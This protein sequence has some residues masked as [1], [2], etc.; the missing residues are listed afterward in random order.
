MMP[1]GVVAAVDWGGTWIRVALATREGD[2]LRTIRRRRPAEVQAQCDLVCDLVAELGG[3]A[4]EPATALGVGIAGITRRGYVES[5][6]NIGIRHPFPLADRL[7]DKS[8]LPTVVV[9]DTQAAAIAEAAVL[10][11]GT[12]VL[13]TAG[14]GI[15]G[16]IVADGRLV[17][18]AGAAGDYGHMVVE[19]DGPACICGGRGCLE[20]VISGRTLN[21]VATRLADSGASQ[22]LV[23]RA[24][25]QG[26]VHAGDL[27]LA[28]QAGDAA[29]SRALAEAAAALV[30]GLRSITAAIDPDVIVLGGGLLAPGL[31]LTAL[32]QERWRTQRPPWTKAELRL[33]SF[34]SEAGLRGAAL[35]ASRSNAANRT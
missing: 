6:S 27:E 19:I 25:E 9:N 26:T 23:T 1:G 16:A 20:Q 30:A 2:L 10:D 3:A 22:W 29:S 12:S 4:C 35:L 14:T 32:V 5:A 13:L 7:R 21:L 34:G 18:G 31:L 33:A 28:A 8:G 11:T 17:T 15:G 24:A